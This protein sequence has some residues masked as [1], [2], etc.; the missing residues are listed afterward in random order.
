LRRVPTNKDAESE[1]T[2]PGTTATPTPADEELGAKFALVHAMVTEGRTDD[3]FIVASALE[4]GAVIAR[5][6][7]VGQCVLA[8][9]PSKRWIEGVSFQCAE[10]DNGERFLKTGDYLSAGS[11]P[12]GERVQDARAFIAALP[13]ILDQ[14]EQAHVDLRDLRHRAQQVL[15]QVTAPAAPGQSASSGE[16][17]L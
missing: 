4:L 7:T 14:L 8:E 13:E 12:L 2:T 10:A 1:K 9:A 17:T 11:R 15:D 3:D 6:M 5:N 16:K